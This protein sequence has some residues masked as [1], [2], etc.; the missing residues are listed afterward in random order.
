MSND[1][2]VREHRFQT[3]GL[4]IAPFRYVG[5]SERRGPIKL[6]DGSEI[7]SPGQPMG[8]CAYCGQGIAICCEIVSADGK[9]F[10]VG[11]DCVEK[12]GDKG[13]VVK[14]KSAVNKLRTEK[15]KAS[16]AKRI[17]E[18]EAELETEELRALLAAKK[19]P[20]QWRA[21]KGETLLDSV[22]WFMARAGNAGKMKT[23]RMVSKL[24]G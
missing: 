16:E 20:Q 24:R 6:A 22:E 7:G 13:I 1:Q 2:D 9:R 14:V 4:G 23:I 18:F 17:A 11:S 10:I 3:A 15:R 19:H 12:T 8:T 21:D 5:F